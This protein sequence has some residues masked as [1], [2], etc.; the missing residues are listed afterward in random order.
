MITVRYRAKRP[1]GGSE[2]RDESANTVAHYR[3]DDRAAMKAT[4]AHVLEDMAWHLK[5]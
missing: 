3:Y 2:W 4:L 1:D 5:T